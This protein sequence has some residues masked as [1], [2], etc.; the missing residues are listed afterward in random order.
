MNRKIQFALAMNMPSVSN[1]VELNSWKTSIPI[2][3][4]IT[5]S[6]ESGHYF[7]DLVTNKKDDVWNFQTMIGFESG[8]LL[9]IHR[10][11][12]WWA[13][14]RIIPKYQSEANIPPETHLLLGMLSTGNYLLLLPLIDQH[15]GFS[16]E[17]GSNNSLSNKDVLTIN[18]H[19]N[20]NSD[21]GSK[22]EML[23][24]R[25]LIISEGDN[26]Y[27]L[28]RTAFYLA[29]SHLHLQLDANIG[30]QHYRAPT[31]SKFLIN[32]NYLNNRF[33]FNRGKGPMF[34]DNLGWCSWDSFYTDL[35][36]S[37]IL[38]G[39]ASFKDTGIQPRFMVNSII[40]YQCYLHF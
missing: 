38:D 27:S 8:K 20:S 1:R 25:A 10:W 22:G 18:G 29:K 16:L 7:L 35:S 2:N 4:I 23:S 24:R 34:I 28:L 19:E 36:T 39:L 37:D 3:S 15:M 17:G 14:P 9:C 40:I 21:S 6:H 30:N 33:K 5:E 13:I 26:L 31:Q 32:S 12:I 11:K